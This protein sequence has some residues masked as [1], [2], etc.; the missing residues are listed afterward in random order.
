MSPLKTPGNIWTEY[1]NVEQ[2]A[3]AKSPHV[4][5]TSITMT[6]AERGVRNGVG[7][8]M[9]HLFGSFDQRFMNIREG[10]GWGP[11]R[12]LAS[13]VLGCSF[14]WKQRFFWKWFPWRDDKR[15][16]CFCTWTE[17][18]IVSATMVDSTLLFARHALEFNSEP[19][20]NLAEMR[21]RF[22]GSC[23]P[24]AGSVCTNVCSCITNK[25]CCQLVTWHGNLCA[26]MLHFF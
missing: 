4:T 12:S 19:V 14:T 11:V 9:G 13:S 10:L 17:K 2:T 1:L 22:I 20:T 7:G 25:V 15:Q 16:P 5:L 8:V 23:S 24:E 6:S 21:F 26:R 18:S 3:A